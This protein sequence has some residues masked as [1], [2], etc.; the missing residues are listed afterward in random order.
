MVEQ[1]T[2]DLGALRDSFNSYLEQLGGL[3]GSDA[4]EVRPRARSCWRSRWPAAR[5][6]S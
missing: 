1:L 2:G 5:N 4:E 3:G 6:A